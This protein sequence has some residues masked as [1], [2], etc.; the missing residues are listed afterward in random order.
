MNAV[1]VH[2]P[3]KINL[4][5]DVFGAR[6]DGYHD[7]ESIVVPF[8]PADEISVKSKPAHTP[9]HHVTLDCDDSSLPTDEGN[10]AFRAAIVFLNRFMPNQPQDVTIR[11]SKKLPCQSDL[12]GGSSDAAA[13]LKALHRI[14]CVDPKELLELGSTIGSD[15]SLFLIG[16]PVL[17]SGRG[18]KVARLITSLSHIFGVIVKPDIEVPTAKAYALV[19]ALKNRV[20]GKSTERLCELLRTELSMEK[21]GVAFNNDFEDAIFQAYPEVAEA[22]RCVAS[23]GAIRALLCGSGSAVFGLARDYDHAT[24]L[25]N[26]LRA[27]F[28]YVTMATSFKEEL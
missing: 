2:A 22:Y 17:M 28:P 1:I 25:V 24:Q 21:L 4:T 20:P 7:L 12:G 15:V 14:F 27:R 16:G 23:A 5:L 10:L 13:V 9:Y 8:T 18:E 3:C 11:L 26:L 6:L 19:D